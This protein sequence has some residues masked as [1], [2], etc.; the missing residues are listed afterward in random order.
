MKYPQNCRIFRF[1]EKN[2]TT[3]RKNC[4][5]LKINP[6]NFVPLKSLLFNYK[7]APRV[8]QIF[9]APV[10]DV[11]HLQRKK[12]GF[13]RFLIGK[14]TIL[15]PL[16]PNSMLESL[17]SMKTLQVLIFASNCMVIS[18][19][20]HVKISMIWRKLPFFFQHW[21]GGKG[22]EM[23]FPYWKIDDFYINAL[24]FAK[25]EVVQEFWAHR[26][27]FWIRHI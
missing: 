15:I 21:T 26:R 17:R 4:L 20:Q 2:K 18:F 10:N 24:F 22:S 16:P 23:S 6:G 14:T 8:Y 9:R 19:H 11:T 3:K 12:Q 7:T 1:A 13:P 25:I 5:L 27:I